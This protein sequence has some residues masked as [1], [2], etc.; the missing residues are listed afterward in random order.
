MVATG[1]RT[2]SLLVVVTILVVTSLAAISG[3]IVNPVLPSIEN[4]FSEIPNAATLAQLVSTLTGLIIAV[5]APIMGYL[6]DKVGRKQVLLGALVLYGTVPPSAFLLDSLYLILATRVFL[7]I[8]VAGITVSATTLIADYYSG[9]RRN[10]LMG[11]QGAIMTVGAAAALI[12]SGVL[13]EIHW[14]LVFLVYLVSLAL[15]PLVVYVID[16]PETATAEEGS[17]DAGGIDLRAALTALPLAF[18]AGVYLTVFIGNIGLNLINVQVPF[19]FESVVGISGSLSGIGLATGILGA[20]VTS[21]NFDRLR[22]RFSP[23]TI[24]TGAFGAVG[25]GLLITGATQRYLIVVAGITIAGGGF[26]LVVPVMNTWVSTTVSEQFRG[27]ALSGIQTTMF[28]GMFVS[29]IA[30]QPLIDRG[31]LAGMFT[32]SGLIAFGLMAVF[33]VLRLRERRG[34]NASPTPADD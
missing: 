6:V 1:E 21:W 24:I 9:D 31:G 11:W 14:K 10:T 17:A 29:P 3:A 28:L 13:A 12:I 2:D 8:A 27:R 32:A 22:E 5:F 7:G 30:A 33:A 20:G 4:A 23:R 34:T 18:L 25:V 19:Y 16:E 15:V 26:G